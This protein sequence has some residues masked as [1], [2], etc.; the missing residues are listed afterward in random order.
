M[1]EPALANR[2]AEEARRL[3]ERSYGW[4]Q[5]VSELEEIYRAVIDGRCRRE[6]AAPLFTA[7]TVM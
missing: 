4:E 1:R 5:S 2:I 3:L 6:P 7:S